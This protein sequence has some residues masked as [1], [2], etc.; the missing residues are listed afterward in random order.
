MLRHLPNI[1]LMAPR[2]GEELAAMLD[3]ALGFG[4]PVA[5][6]Y[7][8]EPLPELPVATRDPVAHGKSETLR[9]GAD[10]AVLA[11]GAM[12][13]PALDAAERAAR[14]G[15]DLTVVNLRFA[16]PLDEERIRALAAG[17]PVLVTVEDG[18]LPGG[19]GSAV[20]EALA[21]GGAARTRL[22][23]LG[24]PDRFIP[25]GTRAELLADLGL[26]AD[27]LTQAFLAAVR[28]GAG[29]AT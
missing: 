1:T 11:Y 8:K 3:A 12:V 13:A 14:E 18:C 7:P 23:R 4:S 24:A 6:R 29:T 26:D 19:V 10:G 9:E 21:D 16:K 5:I 27:G 17:A 22:V 28:D 25:H 15:V 20:A 2:D